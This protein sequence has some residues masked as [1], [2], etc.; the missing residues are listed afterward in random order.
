MKPLRILMFGW[1]FPPKISGGLAT[2]CYGLLK[3]LSSNYPVKVFMVLPFET[4]S[5]LKNIEFINASEFPLTNQK[6]ELLEKLLKKIETLN[7]QEQYF[8]AYITPEKYQ[9]IINKYKEVLHDEI[10]KGKINIAEG[11]GETLLQEIE[12]YGIIGSEIGKKIEHDLIHIHDW[13]TVKAGINAKLSSGK[14]LIMHVHATEFDRSG[15]N[16]NKTIYEIE[17]E[18]ME[19]ADKIIAVS[20][21][22]KNIISKKYGINHNKIE[23]VHNG[24]N[25]FEFDNIDSKKFIKEKI[26][27]FLGRITM[28]KGPF[29]FIEA[30]KLVL[31]RTNNVR[32]VMAGTG[33]LTRKML[34]YVAQSGISDRFHFTGFLNPL[35]VR[36]LFKITDLYV[37]PSVSEPFGITPLEAIQ[38]GVPV[39]LS[40][41]SG[42]SEILNY[43]IK[44][45]FWD[46]YAL[47]DAIYN[48]I[49]NNSLHKMMKCLQMK[50]VCN[51][52]WDTASDK[53]IKLYHQVLLAR[54]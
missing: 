14:P 3:S 11:Y 13:I 52:T 23:V 24:S 43:V 46:T 49:E 1:E 6:V 45:D 54:A 5:N 51:I 39:I 15:E 16:I 27:T 8:S 9:D 38:N 10:L 25:A 50:E 28:Q 7:P 4:N 41:Q 32:F 12:K 21:Y 22:T 47:A 18:G 29:Y 26:V 33:D 36:K 17:K 37:M 34:K 30:A 31:Q 35:E 44:I 20:N 19:K 53:I 40:K 2:A 48:V 42:V